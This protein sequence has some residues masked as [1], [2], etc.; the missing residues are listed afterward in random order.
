MC[1]SLCNLLLY[2]DLLLMLRKVKKSKET[3]KYKFAS[4][5]GYLTQLRRIRSQ[6]GVEVGTRPTVQYCLSM[7]QGT[8]R[9]N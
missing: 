2:V 1:P 7:F 9:G 4:H 6:M 8:I 3:E 5:R